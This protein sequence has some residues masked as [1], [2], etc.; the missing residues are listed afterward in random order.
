MENTK[1]NPQVKQDTNITEL[2]LNAIKEIQQ[3]GI[4]FQELA[5]SLNTLFYSYIQECVHRN[6]EIGIDQAQIY[7]TKVAVDF[8][9]NLH[10]TIENKN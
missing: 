6:T 8:L 5:E 9:R 10:T 7:N 2:Q 4:T 3:D 1:G